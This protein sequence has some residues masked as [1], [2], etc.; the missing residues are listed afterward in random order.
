MP[1]VF[2]MQEDPKPWSRLQG[3]EV[4]TGCGTVTADDVTGRGQFAYRATYGGKLSAQTALNAETH[5]YGASAVPAGDARRLA[6]LVAKRRSG[7]GLPLSM[8]TW[9]PGFALS[10]EC[11]RIVLLGT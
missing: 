9:Q 6:E 10:A 3:Q 11:P 1:P 7:R 8:P 4:R 2:D 5:R